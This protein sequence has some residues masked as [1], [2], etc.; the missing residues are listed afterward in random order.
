MLLPLRAFARGDR[1]ATLV[2]FALVAPVVL[3][4]VVGS[5]DI[6]RCL[7]ALVTITNASREGAH[8]ATMHPDANPSLIRAA[9]AGRVVPLD[10][11]AMTFV[12]TYDAGSG[13]VPWTAT[14]IPSAAVPVP[15][16]VRIAVSYPWQAT[17]WL[18]GSFFSASGQRT[19]SSS[20]QMDTIR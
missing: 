6:A 11:S 2:E 3:L 5:V 1:G 16:T 10:A 17:T 12:A 7:N 20:S 14:G 4:L 9:V 8:Y 15:V 18:V 19:F 13:F